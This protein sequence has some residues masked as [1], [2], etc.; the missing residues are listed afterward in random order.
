[1]K[2]FPHWLFLALAL[3]PGYVAADQD[4]CGGRSTIRPGD[5]FDGD[6]CQCGS[7][8]SNLTVAAPR[9]M[10]LKAACQLEATESGGRSRPVD[11]KKGQVSLDK[12]SAS[13]NYFDGTLLFSGTIVVDGVVKVVPSD[14]G[15]IFVFPNRPRTLQKRFRTPVLWRPTEVDE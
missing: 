8:L 9:G 5:V 4:Q 1:M 7:V 13:G 10:R 2:F 3:I 14:A 6:S 15:N 12:F 11:L